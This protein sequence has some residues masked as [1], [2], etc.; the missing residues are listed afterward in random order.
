[1]YDDFS[2]SEDLEWALVFCTMQ[3]K[4]N[5]RQGQMLPICITT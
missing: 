5:V 4:D 3:K 2:F 1:M